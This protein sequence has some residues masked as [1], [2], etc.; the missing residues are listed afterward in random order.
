[1]LPDLIAQIGTKESGAVG[2]IKIRD[3]PAQTRAAVS[4]L[5]V[6]EPSAPVISANG[7]TVLL[8]VCERTEPKLKR[9]TIRRKLQQSRVEL[10]ARRYLRDLR[11]SAFVDLRG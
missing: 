1:V 5:K 8:I 11:R 3:L 7:S 2:K 10:V 6:G 4:S 9:G